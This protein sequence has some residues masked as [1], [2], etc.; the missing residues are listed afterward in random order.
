MKSELDWQC[1]PY[2]CVCGARSPVYHTRQRDK[3]N[4]YSAWLSSWSEE[5]VGEGSLLS[6]WRVYKFC[7]DSCLELWRVN[8]LVYEKRVSYYI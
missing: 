3:H 6:P 5:I 7:G 1:A 4:R 8:P 2:C